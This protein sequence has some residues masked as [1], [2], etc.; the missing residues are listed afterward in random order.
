MSS[1]VP[2]SIGLL[3]AGLVLCA[4]RAPAETGPPT[5]YS[6]AAYES[7]VRG[8]PDDLLLLAGDRLD[9]DD[10][11]V[12][13]AAPA[14]EPGGGTPAH[15]AEIPAS[16][17]PEL[18]TATIVSAADAPYRLVVH[19]PSV[20][21]NLR[22]Y[23]FW[24]VSANGEWSNGVA[25]NDLRPLWV[26]PAV[27]AASGSIAGLTRDLKLVGRNLS[28]TEGAALS[29][30][31]RGP[32][33]YE[34][35][36]AR[37]AE[38]PALAEYVRVFPLPPILEPGEYRME[39]RV[40]AGTWLPIADQTL[41]VVA[42]APSSRQFAVSD[43]MFGGCR[44]DDGIDDTPC[45][46]RAIASASRAGGGVVAFGRGTWDLHSGALE[47]PAHVDLAGQGRGI[48]RIVRHESPQAAPNSAEFVLLGANRV[49]GITFA[50]ARPLTPASPVH[51]V[52][53][54][55]RRY[56][57]D[58]QPHSVPSPVSD[59][60]ITDNV[61]DKTFGGIIDG[62]NAISRLFVTH[63][64][65]GDYRIGLGLGGNPFNVESRF[66]LVDAVIRENRFLPGSYIDLQARQGVIASEIGA[67]RRVDFSDNVADGANRD[68][69][70]APDDPA[71]WRAAFF[72]HLHDSQEMLLISDNQIS[73]SGDKAGDGEAISLDNNINTFALSESQHVLAA[74]GDSVT[75]PGPLAH[76]QNQREID[77]RTFY[78][79]HWLRIDD[80]AGIGQSRRIV[81][82]E[83]AAD[84]KSVKFTVAPQWDVPP[85]A[86]D[87]RVTVARTFWQTLIVGNTIDQRKPPCLKSN[88]TRP[89]GGNIS[90]W[91]Q[92]TD[93]VVAGNRQYDTDGIVFQEGYG[94]DESGC[95]VCGRGT[96]I[97]SFLDIRANLI[98]GEYA[99]ESSCSL[100]G[101]MGSYAAAPN[102]QSLPPP[103]SFGVS[104]SHNRIVHADSLYGGAINVVPTWYRGPPGYE[105]P[106]LSGLMI[107][108]NEID[109]VAGAPPRTECDYPQ[110]GRY[111]I[112]LQGEHYVAATVLYANRCDAV[113]TPLE[114]QGVHT[115]RLCDAA[116]ANSCE[117]ANAR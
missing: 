15:P 117:C 1:R 104:I 57:T 99:W 31:L 85:R 86:P 87:S 68:F 111:G 41:Q 39:A 20:L 72:W 7:P 35:A 101:I 49:H 115:R 89:K 83:I 26:S 82:Y 2:T 113:A 91:A 96:T 106:L 4:P 64:V 71:G 48:T 110:K 100:S 109:D 116:P 11:I 66:L 90:V 45:A 93:S 29:L 52:L 30:R 17:S 6:Q 74:G 73:C 19:L 24:A 60:V 56:N 59:I 23:R 62:G 103:L 107:D 40:A 70:N 28:S 18:G 32:R 37:S 98:A 9:A 3:L 58:E 38:A 65:I 102:T 63:N 53:Q 14:S 33:D 79:G 114:D 46:A 108:H 88:R 12:Y 80:G 81:G 76:T 112:A 16:S 105:G 84:G 43:P 92:S 21:V 51:P 95:A 27:V 69:L 97:P 34:L 10:R 25:I 47:I 50:E 54:L 22:P 78:V 61:F 67:A 55:G 42:A 13:Q 75:V 44:P 5:L 94:A 8:G 36:P 77:P